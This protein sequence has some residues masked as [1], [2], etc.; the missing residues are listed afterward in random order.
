MQ[1]SA[2]FENDH[3]KRDRSRRFLRLFEIASVL[4]RFDHIAQPHDKRGS[5]SCDRL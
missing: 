5:A 2:R 4:V 1:V 3:L